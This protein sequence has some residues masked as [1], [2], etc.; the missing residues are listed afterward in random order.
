MNAR[1][2]R[3]QPWLGTLVEIAVEGPDAVH[4][5]AAIE[6]AFARIAAIHGAMSFH[7]K[8]VV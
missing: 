2:Q 1:V 5:N 7:G 3:A 6:R 8:S 4:L